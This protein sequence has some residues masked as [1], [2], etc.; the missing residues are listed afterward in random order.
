MTRRG[1]QILLSL[2]QPSLRQKVDVNGNKMWL[3]CYGNGS[4][5]I[6]L[7]HGYDD[8]T[9]SV[10]NKIIPQLAA[11]TQTCAYD[12]I[13]AGI[14]ARTSEPRTMAQ[15]ADELDALLKAAKIEGPY[16]LAGHLF[17]GFFALT[18][19]NH[20]PE[21]V[22]GVVLVDSSYLD[23]CEDI[24]KVLPTPSANESRAVAG[25]RE[26]CKPTAAAW[27]LEGIVDIDPAVRAVQLLG[28]IPLMVLAHGSISKAVDAS[29]G[30]PADL[31]RQ[32]VQRGQEGQKAYTKLSTNSTFIVAEN[33]SHSIQND[34]PQ[35]VID[36]ILGLVDKARQK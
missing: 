25:F 2:P 7:E 24:L 27:K 35:L 26:E 23:N 31:V 9:S 5:T 29:V 3:E 32:L 28:D 13:N 4:P 17:G 1:K 16:I 18:Y 14:S 30:M 33:S 6:I 34:E 36:A 19:A 21:Q 12:R 8:G 22:R 11:Q 10:W 15:A 20:N